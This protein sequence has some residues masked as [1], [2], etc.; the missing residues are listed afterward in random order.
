MP[1]SPVPPVPPRRTEP[2]PDS[3][4]AQVPQHGG[5]ISLPQDERLQIPPLKKL[6]PGLAVQPN[7]DRTIVYERHFHIRAEHA[8]RRGTAHLPLEYG[9]KGF[10]GRNRLL[11]SGRPD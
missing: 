10:I 5:V 1:L 7:G 6:L 4:V 11:R 9:A 3:W 8:G 2:E